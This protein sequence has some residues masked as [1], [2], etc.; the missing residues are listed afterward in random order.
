[1]DHIKTQGTFFDILSF[2]AHGDVRGLFGDSISEYLSPFHL[3]P[4]LSI[5]LHQHKCGKH[6]HKDNT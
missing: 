5:K 4:I 2:G 1:M 6:Q 3:R